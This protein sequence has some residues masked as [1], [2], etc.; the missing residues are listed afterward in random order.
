MPTQL[1][2]NARCLHCNYLL[3][4]L[5]ENKCPECGHTFDPA[6]TDSFRIDA[7]RRRL[8]RLAL[9]PG[10]LHTRLSLIVAF[11][12][13]FE[14]SDPG[15]AASIPLLTCALYLLSIALLIAYVVRLA[16]SFCFA[17]TDHGR[18][19][20]I[21]KAR[22]AHWRWWLFPVCIAVLASTELTNWPLQIRFK[23]SHAAFEAEAAR[24][25]SSQPSSGVTQSSNSR[26]IGLYYVDRIIV[27]DAGPGSRTILFVTT[28][29][30][31]GAWGFARTA[32]G[33]GSLPPFTE[34]TDVGLPRPWYAS[35]DIRP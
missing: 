31:R 29:F 2:E 9:P 1:P 18:A 4:G 19:G 32:N 5:P 14:S 12:L 10:P 30:F 3:K 25:Q 35:A 28:S 15:G 33:P 8:V 22:L 24:Y 27:S 13:L 7:K 21:R 16:A 20:T 17:I 11:L 23:L 34:I 26:R 6:N